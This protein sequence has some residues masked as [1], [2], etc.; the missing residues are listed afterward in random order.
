MGFSITSNQTLRSLYGAYREYSKSSNRENVDPQTLSKADSTA[1]KRA[2]KKLQ[3]SVYDEKTD[4]TDTS[5]KALEYRENLKA[6]IDTYNLTLESSN[7]HNDRSLKR[8]VKQMKELTEKYKNDLDSL[9]ITYDSDGFMKLNPSTS[10]E[11]T[12][13]YEALFGPKADFMNDLGKI[14]NRIYRHINIVI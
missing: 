8:A 2:I 10:V 6:F 1:L 5:G 4:L 9:G 12:K 14:P 3:N 13:P 7:K 11:K